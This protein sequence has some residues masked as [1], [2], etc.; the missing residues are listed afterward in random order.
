MSNQ[1]PQRPEQQGT[2][3]ADQLSQ[4]DLLLRSLSGEIQLLR[5]RLLHPLPQPAEN[6]LGDLIVWVDS[7]VTQF[8]QV[9]HNLG[10][11]DKVS[12]LLLALIR[13]GSRLRAPVSLDP[14]QA[15]QQ[16]TAQPLSAQ[17]VSATTNQ[18]AN[19]FVLPKFQPNANG[20]IH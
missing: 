3:V 18:P 15:G 1:A 13:D 17:H 9:L 8:F 5:E 6:R 4:T 10:C 14:Q 20:T 11:Q 16:S 12:E 2:N 19:E 7:L